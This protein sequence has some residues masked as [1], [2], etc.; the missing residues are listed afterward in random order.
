MNNQASPVLHLNQDGTHSSMVDGVEL[1]RIHAPRHVAHGIFDIVN[2]HAQLAEALH[3]MVALSRPY[4]TDD[5]QKL[6]LQQAE[7]ALSQ[8]KGE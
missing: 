7:A 6:A 5:V 4:F 2:S 8:A 1:Y 3:N